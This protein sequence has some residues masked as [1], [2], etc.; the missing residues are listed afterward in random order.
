MWRFRY[1]GILGVYSVCHSPTGPVRADER[2]GT[3][4]VDRLRGD[5][6]ES[7]QAAIT[8]TIRGMVS[9]A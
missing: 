4:R 7:F 9:V 1:D 3:W 8:D 2:P 5:S 6:Y